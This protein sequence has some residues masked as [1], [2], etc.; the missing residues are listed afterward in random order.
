MNQDPLYQ[1]IT[2]T[3]GKHG[4]T[5]QGGDMD[6]LVFF[7]GLGLL[8][9]ALVII[10][11]LIER[12]ILTKKVLKAAVVDIAAAVET[13]AKAAIKEV[14]KIFSPDE[15]TV[16]ALQADFA[17]LQAKIAQAEKALA[18]ELAGIN[19][20]VSATL[21]EAQQLSQLKAAV[22]AIVVAPAVETQAPPAGG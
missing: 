20:Q 8:V 21:A 12:K 10:G 13:D 14:E 9:F 19:A 4:V 18:T 11:L 22:G 16:P 2:E 15:L 17:T 1:G 6:T 3:L 5:I 7:L